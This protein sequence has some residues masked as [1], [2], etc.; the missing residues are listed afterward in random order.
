[1]KLSL[2][3]KVSIFLTLVII[4]ISVISTYLFTS[5]HSRSKEKGRI[6][7]GTALCYALSKAAEEGLINENLDL[8]KKASYIIKAPD[9][10]MVQ[11]YSNLW[12]AI[13]AYP[14]E[15]L[16]ER[17]APEAVNHFNIDSSSFYIKTAHGYDFY[18][19]VFLRPSEDSPQ[20]IIGYGRI[21]L[22]SLDIQKEI[23][24]IVI[25]NIVVSG[26]ITLIAILIFNIL[27]S[28]IVIK[29]V[30]NLHKSVAM[31]KNGALPEAAQNYPGDEIGEL[32][33][34]FHKM[35]HIIKENTD[36]LIDSE[37]R[38]KSLFERVEH[39]IFRLDTEGNIIE[40]NSKFN[41]LFGNIK[42]LCT[43]IMSEQKSADCMKDA[44]AGNL[45]QV[46]EKLMGRHGDELI[47]LL[48]IY[49]E[50]DSGGKIKGY[51]GYIIDLTEKKRLEERLIRSQKLEAVG[52]LAGGIAHDF[53]NVLTAILGYAEIIQS[54]TKEGD[55]FYKPASI[56]LQAAKKGADFSKKI[57]SVTRKEKIEA[58]PVNINVIVRDSLELL[59]RSIPKNIEVITRLD[60]GIPNI[61]ADPSQIQQVIINLAVNSRDAMPEGGKLTIETSVV[62][63]ENGA[64][65]SIPPTEGGFIKLSISDTGLGIDKETQ[66][67]IFDPFFTTKVLGKGTGLGLYI[68]H[69]IISNHGGYI[70]L[71]SEPLKGT[72]FN[73]YLPVT[74]SSEAEESGK[75]EDL[76]GSGTILIIDDE[77]DVR[78]L[79]KDMLKPLGYKVLQA[80]DGNAGIN[81]YR[82]M[83][84][85]ISLVLLD[86][87]MP[88]M[89]GN[90][91]FQALKTIDDKVKVLICSGYSRDG[92]T[93]IAELMKSGVTGF[94]QKPFSRQAM[95]TAIKKALSDDKS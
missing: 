83:K 88:K 84:D 46:E 48:S 33:K 82:E 6:I 14:F 30:M 56:I 66:K 34:E 86:M 9:V 74:Q 3:T 42:T 64:A 60:D 32:S 29:P 92:F 65:S 16:K 80:E 4:I 90:E 38:I 27:I 51:D 43:L 87:V 39:A 12:D 63:K 93:G 68:V 5:A 55:P 2:K 81:I 54:M 11:V 28:R 17:P 72:C 35:S 21:V 52:T 37:K 15:R 31:F 77:S 20:V 58:R 36:K 18:S 23:R 45:I 94:L 76:K 78:E 95:A 1:M 7:R 50:M 62:G 44:I 25:T 47:V 70:N 57:L 71:Y 26:A 19:P 22:S 59:Q 41:T 49:P 85:N 79:C 10:L 91:V 73:I 53:N 75:I 89:S 40:T 13:D 69:S 8:I 24:G 67:K 61:N